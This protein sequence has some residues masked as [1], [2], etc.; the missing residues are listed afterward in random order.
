MDDTRPSLRA[1]R[2]SIS[3]PT[4][5][6]VKRV[7]YL[8]GSRAGVWAYSVAGLEEALG[9]AGF[10]RLRSRS[11]RLP[12]LAARAI[13]KARIGRNVRQRAT[14]ALLVPF[15]GPAEYRLVPAGLLD[16]AV[17][18]AYDC[19]PSSYGRWESIFRRY[20]VRLAF[21]SARASADYFR[22]KID[23]LDA[24]WTPEAVDPSA[25]DPGPPLSDRRCD[26]L[27][28]GRRDPTFHSAITPALAAAGRSHSYEQGPGNLVFPD[29]PSLV[30][31]LAASTISVCFPS[32]MTHPARSGTVETVTHR[33]FESMASRCLIVGHCPAELADLF[34]YN[35]VVEVDRNGS[36]DQVL[37]LLADVAACQELVDRNLQRLFEVGTWDV[38]VREIADA[39]RD[40]GYHR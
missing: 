22:E 24:I 25:Y 19:W 38:R 29:R 8:A 31:G 40:R 17:I 3:L 33:Y 27:E 12:V 28:F 39:L 30:Q 9:R 14:R 5:G 18:Y 7:G 20:R 21:F 32:S 23:G 35:P 1:K 36:A 37:E 26:V 6:Q 34:G 13:A 4:A 10:R 11:G 15:M 16:E 2:R